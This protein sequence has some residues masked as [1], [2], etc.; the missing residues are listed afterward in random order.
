[1]KKRLKELYWVASAKKELRALPDA[2]VDIFGY[3]LHLAQEGMKHDQA[4]PLK[5]LGGVLEVVE[6]HKGDT[7]RAVY[8]AKFGDAVYVLYCFQKKSKQGIKTPKPDMDVIR[9]R[10]KAAKAHAEGEEDE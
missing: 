8:T 3:A 6:D 9:Q 7:Y 4:K 10:L 1:M 2:V 5:G